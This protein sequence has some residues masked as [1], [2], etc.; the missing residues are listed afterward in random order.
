MAGAMAAQKRGADAARIAAAPSPA[1]VARLAASASKGSDVTR[2]LSA[3]QTPSLMPQAMPAKVLEMF[4]IG[5]PFALRAAV[6]DRHATQ[7]T[8]VGQLREVFDEATGE[9]AARLAEAQAAADAKSA[10]VEASAAKVASF[11]EQI[12]EAD[13]AIEAQRNAVGDKHEAA[14]AAEKELKAKEAAHKSALKDQANFTNQKESFKAIETDGIDVLAEGTAAS[15]KDA[16]K[17][18]NKLMKDLGQLGAE[19]SLLASAPA[20]L[21]KAKDQRQSFD[22]MVID[23]LRGTLAERVAALDAALEAGAAAGQEAAAAVEAHGAAAE[24]CRQA[25][26]AER[27]ALQKLEARRSETQEAKRAGEEAADALRARHA[28]E[29]VQVAEAQAAVESLRGASDAFESLASRSSAA[30][31]QGAPADAPAAVPA[32]DE[33]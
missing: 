23:S 2:I 10:E 15:E 32:R 30:P 31:A 29:V 12:V 25:C 22:Q 7:A 17:V 4:V 5:A 19:P 16:K 6:E 20:V 13:K 11:A 14:R 3:L 9:L 18:C 26:D 33:A 24:A 27:E 8:V 1:K 21:L 28:E